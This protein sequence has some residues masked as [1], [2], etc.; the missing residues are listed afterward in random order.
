MSQELIRLIDQISRDKGI[1]KEVLIEAIESAVLSASRRYFQEVHHLIARLNRSSGTM[2]F[3]Q[4]KKEAAEE[5]DQP[6][7]SQSEAPP[8]DQEAPEEIPVELKVDA[9]EFGR[10]AA[11]TAKQII[12]QRVR[13]A[14]RDQIYREY[15][16]REGELVSGVI[17]RVEGRDFMIDLGRIEAILPYREQVPWEKYQ[18]KNR[19]RAYMLEVIKSGRG[20]QVILS[21]SHPDFVLRLFEL[22]VPE[23]TEGILEIKGVV[24]E[25]GR[26]TKIAV[27]S[28]DS[29]VDPVGTCVGVKGSRVQ[30]VLRELENE[31]IDIIRWVEDPDT[32]VCH[33]LSP[34]KIKS[35]RQT[36][37]G[38]ME[39]VV[40]TDQLSLAIGK[41]GQNVRLA[42]KLTGWK[43]DIRE[44]G[45]APPA[46]GE[47]IPAE[48][49]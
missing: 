5:Q 48:G 9:R 41:K 35:I 22:E 10:I 21:R 33:A 39:V 4:V 3:F 34:A 13:E 47:E 42:S 28:N 40:A 45:G 49:E 1:E 30:N 23:I 18:R 12:M 6:A 46:E 43:I 31:K 27:Q 15:K 32:Y 8:T 16:E 25:A 19:I 17:Q 26:R 29:K 24:R 11:H 7:S 37:P 36:D 14:E 20:P 44:A 38:T 2:E